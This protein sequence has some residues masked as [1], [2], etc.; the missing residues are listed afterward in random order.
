MT[1]IPILILLSRTCP[2][3]LMYTIMPQKSVFR[4]LIMHKHAVPSSPS[5]MLAYETALANLF[6]SRGKEGLITS[7]EWQ[8]MFLFG[9]P[10]S[11]F[12]YENSFPA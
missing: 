8:K 9:T 4:V 11:L 5:Q 2:T 12:K 1:A 3:D 7:N 6:S 10:L